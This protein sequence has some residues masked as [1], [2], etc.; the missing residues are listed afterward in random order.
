MK[1]MILTLLICLSCVAVACAAGNGEI[2][3]T[4]VG[5]MKYHFADYNVIG[6]N[7]FVIED[8]GN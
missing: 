1:L 6:H 2:Y 8:K 5:T 7:Q 3:A 4:V